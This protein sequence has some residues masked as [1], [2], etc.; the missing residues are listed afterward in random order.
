MVLKLVAETWTVNSKAWANSIEKDRSLWSLISPIEVQK[1]NGWEREASSGESEALRCIVQASWHQCEL[2]FFILGIPQNVLINHQ[3]LLIHHRPT[4]LQV[5]P[6]TKKR[7][8][9]CLIINNEEFNKEVAHLH[10]RHGSS[11]DAKNLC[12]L[13]CQ[14]GFEV[15]LLSGNSCT[16]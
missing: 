16:A 13:F 4:L 14:L 15:T 5:Y 11:V 10:T 6:M 3:W 2:D 9:F 12:E 7:R 1:Q 8:G